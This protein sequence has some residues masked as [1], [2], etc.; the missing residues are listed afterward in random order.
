MILTLKKDEPNR[1]TGRQ[2]LK[3]RRMQAG[4]LIY[5]YSLF[6]CCARERLRSEDDNKQSTMKR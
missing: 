6:V 2:M 5:E 4:N 1:M 3:T